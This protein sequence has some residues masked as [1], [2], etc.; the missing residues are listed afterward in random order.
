MSNVDMSK[1]RR[2]FEDVEPSLLWPGSPF[3]GGVELEESLRYQAIAEVLRRL[4]DQDFEMLD[5]K[6]DDFDWFIPH[7]HVYG[8]IQPFP[9]TQQ[10]QLPSG[11]PS[12]RL[13]VV[14][15]LSPKLEEEEWDLVVAVVAHELAHLVLG[16]SLFSSNEDY[17]RN[18][19]EVDAKLHEWGF[20]TEVLIHAASRRFRDEQYD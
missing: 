1:F 15:Y 8:R 5:S 12:A 13:A 2:T 17:E 10:V 11:T 9:A 19:K 16:H 7:E 3:G 4:P 6:V 18:E 20:E 14:L